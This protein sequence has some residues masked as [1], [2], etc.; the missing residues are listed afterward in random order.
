MRTSEVD[1]CALF[2]LGLSLA[3]QTVVLAGDALMAV[4]LLSDFSKLPMNGPGHRWRFYIGLTQPPLC[5]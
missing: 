2:Y 1:E 3:K 5:C 4:S